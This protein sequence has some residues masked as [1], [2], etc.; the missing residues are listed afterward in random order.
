MKRFRLFTRCLTALLILQALGPVAFATAQALEPEAA[1]AT[2]IKH[3][4]VIMQEN[5]TF[6]NY[7]GTFPGAEGIP[8]DVCMPLDPYDPNNTDCIKPFHI[9]PFFPM[10]DLDHSPSTFA[11]Q[12]N[13]GKMDSF[14]Y[15]LNKRN[16]KGPLSMGYYDESD[17][18][19]YWNLA[20]EYVLFDHLFSSGRSGSFMNHM[21]WVAGI[22]GNDRLQT[23][24]Y[25]PDILTIFDR[26]EAKGVSWKFYVQNYD[27]N[28]TYRNLSGYGSRAS[29]VIWVP[30][31]NFDRFID[32]PELASHIVD[33][34]QYYVDL[35]NGTLPAVAYLAPSGASE[36]PPGSIQSG[37]K[38]VKVL[39]QS[40]M[41]SPAWESSAFLL[42]YD[43]WG[44]WFDHVNPPQVDDYG[45]G[46]RV[47]GILVSPY[48][49]MGIVNHSVF[50]FT[51][52]LK[53]IEDNWGV[54]PLHTRDAQAN[55]LITAF[56]FSQPPRPPVFV[57]SGQQTTE[58]R[59][60]ASRPVIYTAY[61][62]ALIFAFFTILWAILGSLLHRRSVA[63]AAK[64]QTMYEA[65]GTG[66]QGDLTGLRHE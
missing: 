21:Y 7:F 63:R 33:L 51:S 30:L 58:P 48:A 42:V 6:D 53:F 19:Y 55:S 52:I 32:D 8:P 45:Y 37:Q 20:R 56:N 12:Y 9:D 34:N 5:H 23:F 40:L 27:P 36:H 29:Q 65:S 17:L 49:P 50:D 46:F 28:I 39:I 66:P 26:L 10:Q 31:L 24:A 18:P 47:P 64:S 13:D 44:G 2:P 35:Q 1:T 25:G 41:Q 60:E 22:P 3:F 16:Q 15:A 61:G 43:D 38:F 57:S 54:E 11:G 59:K 62:A 14:V 4:V